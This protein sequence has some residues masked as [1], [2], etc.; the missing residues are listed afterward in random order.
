MALKTGG[1][2]LVR[3]RAHRWAAPP[4]HGDA[5]GWSRK[6]PTYGSTDS[7]HLRKAPTRRDWASD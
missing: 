4:A 3:L 2:A 1:P 5:K 6:E 7:E